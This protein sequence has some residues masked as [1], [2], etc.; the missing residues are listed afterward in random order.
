MLKKE[1]KPTQGP[2][3]SSY[4]KLKYSKIFPNVSRR[5]FRHDFNFKHHTLFPIHPKHFITQ[6]NDSKGP[7][8]GFKAH[9]MHR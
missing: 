8:Q 2:S 6:T 7:K 4:A 3:T 5:P 1:R 9:M